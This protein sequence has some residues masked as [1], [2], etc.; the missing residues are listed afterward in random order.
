MGL[1]RGGPWW[2]MALGLGAYGDG[3]RHPRDRAIGG[4]ALRFLQLV[5]LTALPLGR[6]RRLFRHEDVRSVLPVRAA[7]GHRES[8]LVATPSGL[9]IVS[10]VPGDRS[11][12]WRTRWAPWD[13]VHL[14]GGAADPTAV[15]V[16]RVRFDASLPGG[17]GRRA[18]RDFVLAARERRASLGAPPLSA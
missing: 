4:L 16:D 9:A 11:G 2:G 18:R 10:A 14:G 7:R 6:I 13:A 15:W 17:A 12:A 1:S 8:L 5:G 3:G